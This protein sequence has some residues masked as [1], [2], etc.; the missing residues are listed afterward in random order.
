L[1]HRSDRDHLPRQEE[2]YRRCSRSRR[3]VRVSFYDACRCFA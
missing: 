1:R 2:C 3:A